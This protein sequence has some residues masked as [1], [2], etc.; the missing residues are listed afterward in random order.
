MT[1]IIKPR[2]FILKLT[3]LVKLSFHELSNNCN[4]LW[5]KQVRIVNK[6]LL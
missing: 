3:L 2:V 5:S 4:T 1:G 6:I